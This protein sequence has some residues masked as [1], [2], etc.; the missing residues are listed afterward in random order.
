MKSKLL[1]FVASMIS[2]AASV[3]VKPLCIFFFHQPKVPDKL[4]NK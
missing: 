4:I 3:S 2:S 1:A